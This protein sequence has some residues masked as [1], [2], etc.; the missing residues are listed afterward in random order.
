MSS[1][2]FLNLSPVDILGWIILLQETDLCIVDGSAH[3]RPL[4][5]TPTVASQSGSSHCQM[6]SGVKLSSNGDHWPKEM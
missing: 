4:P 2:A 5:I 1:T 6:A 3:P